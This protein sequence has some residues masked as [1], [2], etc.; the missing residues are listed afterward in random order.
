MARGA[1][2]GTI[3][4]RTDALL[5]TKKDARRICISKA[6]RRCE[7]ESRLSRERVEAGKDAA[8]DVDT[9]LSDSEAESESGVVLEISGKE[10]HDCE[11][12][13]DAHGMSLADSGVIERSEGSLAQDMLQDSIEG[14]GARPGGMTQ[15]RLAASFCLRIFACDSSS[16]HDGSIV[17]AVVVIVVVVVVVVVV[18]SS[19]CVAAIVVIGATIEQGVAFK[20][21]GW[22]CWGG[23]GNKVRS[24]SLLRRETML[25]CTLV[26]SDLARS[27]VRGERAKVD[28]SFS[29]PDNVRE[30]D[31]GSAVTRMLSCDLFLES[32]L[33]VRVLE[34]VVGEELVLEQALGQES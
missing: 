32:V 15:L 1:L 2:D 33:L 29:A 27:N 30:G 31:S 4:E 17:S 23:A 3:V 18:V 11:A 16:V 20:K 28:A 10:T 8:E 26:R 14:M 9:K 24:V 19:I 34:R 25:S 5:S 12:N 7:S 21:R 22:H 6:H 13:G